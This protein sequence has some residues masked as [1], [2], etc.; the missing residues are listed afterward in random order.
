MGKTVI[1]LLGLPGGGKTTA[2]EALADEYNTELYRMGDVVRD[3]FAEVQEDGISVFPEAVQ[4]SIHTAVSDEAEVIPVETSSDSIGEWVTMML[5]IHETV[6]AETAAKEITEEFESDIIIV[7]GIRTLSDIEA[8]KE[9]FERF[10]LLHIYTP[11]VVRAERLI[12]RGR[13]GEDEFDLSDVA[14]RDKRELD[15]GVDKILSQNTSSTFYNNSD[16][17]EEFQS[18]IVTFTKNSV[19]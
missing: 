2:G 5:D 13:E 8:F 11:F 1:G 14:E 10:E 7:D 19:L 12:D 6:F 18:E 4:D 3:S 17:I 15:W 9:G 16:S